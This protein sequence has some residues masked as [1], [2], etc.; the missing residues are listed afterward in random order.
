MSQIDACSLTR[1]C[2]LNGSPKALRRRRKIKLR[3]PERRERIH[4]RVHG[5]AER[6][7]RPRLARALDAEQI[8][9]AGHVV[10]R[11]VEACKIIGARHGVIL[12]RAREELARSWIEMRVFQE[13][14][15]STLGDAAMNLP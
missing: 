1:F 4:N 12:E 14:L 8:G 15:P 7:D 2:L 10:K 13:H 5:G 9:R 3:D 11:D 6:A